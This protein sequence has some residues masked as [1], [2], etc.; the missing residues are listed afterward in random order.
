VSRAT[1]NEGHCGPQAKIGTVGSS[2]TPQHTIVVPVCCRTP[3]DIAIT[4]N[5]P[6]WL[7]P[8]NLTHRQD[9]DRTEA[10]WRNTSP[11]SSATS[12]FETQR[13]HIPAI[14]LISEFENRT[15]KQL[16]RRPNLG[17]DDALKRVSTTSCS[18]SRN[19]EMRQDLPL[20]ARGMVV[21]AQSMSQ[22]QHSKRTGKLKKHCKGRLSYLSHSQ[23]LNKSDI[24]TKVPVPV[25]S[26]EYLSADIRWYDGL[27][28][29][30]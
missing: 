24:G 4:M 8:V 28:R 17:W 27:N 11:E 25:F 18:R 10:L 29:F 1:L 9:R 13:N 2:N 7:R 22:G 20:L 3:K 5:Q 30:L 26:Q 21:E 14:G 15:T 6:K 19:H 16:H 23:L 12:T